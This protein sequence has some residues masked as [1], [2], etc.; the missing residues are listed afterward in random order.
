LSEP[1]LGI[2]EAWIAEHTGTIDHFFHLAAIY[3]MTADADRNRV[4][5]VEGTRH[6][7]EVANAL[8]AGHLHHVSSVAAAGLYEGTFT[9]DMF[10]E[11]QPLEHPYNATK[12]KSERIEREDATNPWRVYRPS[13]VVG[14]SQTGDIG[15]LHGPDSIL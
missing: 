6:A 8:G 1:R 11:R 2:D 14:H 4:A 9:E 13:T 5:N 10:D 15:Q 3:D 7:V 12:L